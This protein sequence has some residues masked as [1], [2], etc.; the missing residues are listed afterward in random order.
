[1]EEA[2]RRMVSRSSEPTVG[3]LGEHR[4]TTGM[5]RFRK[6]MASSLLREVWQFYALAV[7]PRALD[8][9]W[10]FLRKHFTGEL[11]F[12]ALLFLVAW[13]THEDKLVANLGA[14]FV[15][16]VKAVVLFAVVL[17]VV[18][19]LLAP[20]RVNRDL[21]REL[22]E[23]DKQFEIY[24]QKRG[25]L[26]RQYASNITH[27]EPSL[28]AIQRQIGTEL[29][30]ILRKIEMVKATNPPS[31]P[32]GF[33][34]PRARF[35]Q[36]QERLSELPDLYA[37]VERAYSAAHHVNSALDMRRARARVGWTIGVHPDD[38]LDDAY[39]AAGEALDAMDESRGEVF[40]S[41]LDR[42]ARRVLEDFVREDETRGEGD[43]RP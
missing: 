19:L 18:E 3:V 30:D 29:R 11:C 9:S 5:G 24:L 20:V 21:R 4:E 8:D 7:I 16:L 27:I 33:Q 26:A 17:F 35:T 15:L 41:T 25:A 13:F 2:S 42:T 28:A 6:R 43:K 36:Y 34:L 32:H 31:Y 23:K 1:M 10:R 12:A 39:E 37:I 22:V 38:R 14:S 40:E